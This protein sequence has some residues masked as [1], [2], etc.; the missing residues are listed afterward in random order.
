[1]GTGG[2]LIATHHFNTS[3]LNA[4]VANTT[5]NAPET[6]ISTPGLSSSNYL[7]FNG[8]REGG[9]EGERGRGTERD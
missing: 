4:G 6:Y 3:F 8:M 7:F 9:R 2:G 5:V 1:M